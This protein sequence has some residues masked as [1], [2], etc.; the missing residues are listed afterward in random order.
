METSGHDL[1]GAD[2]AG[3]SVG[4]GLTAGHRFYML[5]VT[6]GLGLVRNQSL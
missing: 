6:R 4:L 3:F 2:K 1:D 5:Y